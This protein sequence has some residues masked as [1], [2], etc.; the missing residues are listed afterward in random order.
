MLYPWKLLLTA[1]LPAMP[2][3]ALHFIS[4]P[5]EIPIILVQTDKYLLQICATHQRLLHLKRL[6]SGRSVKLFQIPDSR[7]Q[8]SR[9]MYN[10]DFL[11][12]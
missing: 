3:H 5:E 6:E 2:T 9:L 1:F 12:S 11:P 8:A 4:C 10:G 7:F